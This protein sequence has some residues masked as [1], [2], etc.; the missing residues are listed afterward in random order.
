MHQ[1]SDGYLIQSS[2]LL[3]E[4]GLIAADRAALPNHPALAAGYL[5]MGNESATVTR[6]L[7]DLGSGT[8]D[9]IS[10]S[11]QVV[12]TDFTLSTVSATVVRKSK[13]RS[14]S[15]FL[16]FFDQTGLLKNPAGLAMDAAMIRGNTLTSMIAVAAAT[17]S[18][19]VSV[20]SG[21]SLTYAKFLEAKHS[22]IESGQDFAD[23][24][25]LC[26][27][28]PKQWNNLESQI[29]VGTSLSNAVLQTPEAYNMQYARAVGYQGR[30]NGIDIFTSTRVPT[31]NAGADSV[32]ALIAPGG[33][34]W[35][36][37]AIE[38]D[39]D[40]FMDVLDGGRLQI[41]RQRD[42][43]RMLKAIYYNFLLGVSLGED[44]R[45]RT[46]TSDR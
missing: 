23:G 44:A 2:L 13:A 7:A 25:L 42:A 41:E 5:G 24:E 31:A 11:G 37:G 10:E 1:H 43:S 38:P 34:A 45:V 21:T 16:K 19:G 18:S 8:A 32:G 12:A 30:L 17:A 14:R 22:L 39:P 27:L 35:A 4:Y 15:D 3:K 20:T 46:I 33:I 6:T 28:H 36:E 40:G 26:V 9:T 29:S